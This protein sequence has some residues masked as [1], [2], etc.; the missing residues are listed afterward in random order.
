MAGRAPSGVDSRVSMLA[1][2]INLAVD[3]TSGMYSSETID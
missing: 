3:D 2:A 1:D